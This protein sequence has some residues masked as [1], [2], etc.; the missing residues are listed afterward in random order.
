MHSSFPVLVS[1]QIG[2]FNTHASFNRTRNMMSTD[3]NG[4]ILWNTSMFYYKKPVLGPTSIEGKGNTCRFDY[5]R[6]R[7][8][9]YVLNKCR[10]D[11]T[12]FRVL[13]PTA[14]DCI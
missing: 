13:H 5:Q 1:W 6:P 14:A 8:I 2:F 3:A 9:E 10:Y 4:S 12:D 11:L 7:I